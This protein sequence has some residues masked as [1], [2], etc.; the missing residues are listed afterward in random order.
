VIERAVLEHQHEDV[1]NFS[2]AG[3]GEMIHLQLSFGS[4]SCSQYGDTS[5]SEVHKLLFSCR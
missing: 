2:V 3:L 5:L 1:T 4:W